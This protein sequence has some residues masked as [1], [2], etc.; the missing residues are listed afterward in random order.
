MGRCCPLPVHINGQRP[1]LRDLLKNILGAVVGRCWLL[2]VV[3]DV[4]WFI[5]SKGGRCLGIVNG[6]N[7]CVVGNYL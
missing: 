2:C 1:L 6:V 7:S 5:F 3:N 4:I